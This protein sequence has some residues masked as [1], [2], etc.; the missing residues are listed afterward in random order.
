MD[1]IGVIGCSQAE[2]LKRFA[3]DILLDD[4][5]RIFVDVRYDREMTI[6]RVG[7][8]QNV[9]NLRARISAVSIL[10]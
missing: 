6:K 1:E 5:N 9:V 4:F 7:E 3:C 10:Q 8:D 2:S